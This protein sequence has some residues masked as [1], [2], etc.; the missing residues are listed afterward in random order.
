MKLPVTEEQ[1]QVG[2]RTVDTQRTL[3]VRKQVLHEPVELETESVF[4]TV[5]VERVKVGR[6]VQEAPGVRQE[7]DVTV[8]PLVE[9]RA[10]VVKQLVLVEELRLTRRREVRTAT[11]EATLRKEQVAVERFDPESKQWLPEDGS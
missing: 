8:V 10:V 1:L 7:G 9:E 4:E 2:R 6:V 11:A 5:E 3:R